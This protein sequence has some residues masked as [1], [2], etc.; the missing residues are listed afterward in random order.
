MLLPMNHFIDTEHA[1]AFTGYRPQKLPFQ[2]CQQIQSLLQQQLQQAILSAAAHGYTIYLNG[3]MSGWDILAAETVIL[4]QRTHPQLSCITIA[5]FKRQY[6][7]NE[8][9]ASEW[10]ARALAVYKKSDQSFYMSENY[11][12]GI[13]YARDRYLVDHAS[14]IIAYYDGKNGGTQ[15]TLDYAAKQKKEIVNIASFSPF[16]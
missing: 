9:W 6:F 7:A 12:K 14:L 15:Y 2:C 4:L 16:L 8:N 13:Y 1:V 5:P 10:K 11:T 3:C